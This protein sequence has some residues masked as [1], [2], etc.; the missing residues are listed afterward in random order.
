M[1]WCGPM[2]AEMSNNKDEAGQKPVGIDRVLEMDRLEVLALLEGTDQVSSKQRGPPT[3]S[4][5]APRVPIR[6]MLDISEE[7]PSGGGTGSGQAPGSSKSGMPNPCPDASAPAQRSRNSSSSATNS[8]RS[9]T[10]RVHFAGS[11]PHP[12]SKSD[13][14]PRP[15]ELRQRGSAGRNDPLSEYRPSSFLSPSSGSQ[16]QRSAS[17]GGVCSSAGDVLRPGDFG[18]PTSRGSRGRPSRAFGG[19][20]SQSPRHRLT[21]RS[22]SPLA[23]SMRRS[24]QSA[25]DS[26]DFST[27]YRRLSDGNLALS[28]GSLSQLPLRQRAGG[29]GEGRLVKDYLGPDGEHLGSSDEEDEAVASDDEVRG[30][31]KAPG[32]LDPESMAE[33]DGQRPRS[34]SHRQGKQDL[35]LLAASEDEGTFDLPY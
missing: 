22:R 15:L 32:A 9:S 23:G 1:A 18:I 11:S 5:G 4:L 24:S 21:N 17:Q 10:P 13:G 14:G 6:S 31:R 33:S 34:H 7:K 12:R 16:T 19:N 26:G 3:G 29:P 20:R 2:P 30:R 25:F 27:A 8:P 28:S 35:T